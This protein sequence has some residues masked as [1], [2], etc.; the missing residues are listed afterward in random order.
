MKSKAKIKDK[1]AQMNSRADIEGLEST[2]IHL[3]KEAQVQDLEP[4]PSSI[5]RAN[6]AA[7]RAS[8]KYT[9]FCRFARTTVL[10]F[11]LLAAAFCSCVL[12]LRFGSAFWFCV[13]LIEDISCVLPREDSARFKT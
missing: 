1:E 4:S 10:R 13:L 12:V 6:R 9:A 7:M 8:I 2:H 11:V 5:N 3:T